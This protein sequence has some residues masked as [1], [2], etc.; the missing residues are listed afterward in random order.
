MNQEEFDKL[1][2]KAE[3]AGIEALGELLLQLMKAKEDR[4]A[5]QRFQLH[6]KE[7]EKL[8]TSDAVSRDRVCEKSPYHYCFSVPMGK[9]IEHFDP[10][11][12][13]C[14]WCNNIYDVDLTKTEREFIKGGKVV[15]SQQLLIDIISGNVR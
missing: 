2:F 6:N 12:F 10:E 13:F 1:Y 15:G 3:L 8:V 7:Y 11:S 4:F 14:I 5:M 9:N